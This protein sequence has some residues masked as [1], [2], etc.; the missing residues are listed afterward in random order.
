MA[1]I[2]HDAVR[3]LGS[4]RID[5]RYKGFS[6]TSAT[7]SVDELLELRPGLFSNTFSGAIMTLDRHA[8]DHNVT[9]MAAWCARNDVDLAPHGKTTM[10]PK[11]VARQIAAGAWGLTVATVGQARVFRAF[12]VSPI[13]IA[14]EV[15]DPIDV[16]WLASAMRHDRKARFLCWVDSVDGVRMLSDAL[17]NA[18]APKQ[19]DVLVEWGAFG[20]RTGCRSVQDARAV[21]RIAADAPYL[22]LVG[23][24]GYE[25]V[26]AHDASPESVTIV[27]RYLSTLRDV[28]LTLADDGVFRD[29]DG[30][31]ISAGGSNYF[32]RVVACMSKVSI[33]GCRV[34]L[35][36]GCYVTHDDGYYKR[37][38]PQARSAAEAPSFLPAIRVWARVNSR[39]EA[40]LALLTMGRRDISYDEGFPVPLLTRHADDVE[41]LDDCTVSGLNDQHTYLRLP[42]ENPLSVGDWVA[43]GISHPCSMFDRWRLIPVVDG[44]NVVDLIQTFF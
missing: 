29:A 33:T 41:P 43:C 42:S 21:A 1:S 24:A 10:A 9:S 20:G 22:R 2:D 36:S 28:A 34:L 8:I 26:L 44:D 30:I 37:T 12:G 17:G 7:M 11:L 39:P 38:T 23:V 6:H 31:I 35:R 25:G 13:V 18:A 14:N 15:I 3:R 5:W 19:V 16:A 40:E 27:D 4:E 32:D